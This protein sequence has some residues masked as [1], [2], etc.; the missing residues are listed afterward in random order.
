MAASQ[1]KIATK[2]RERGKREQLPEGRVRPWCLHRAAWVCLLQ[3]SGPLT[4]RGGAGPNLNTRRA[5]RLGLARRFVVGVH[6]IDSWQS[7]KFRPL[8][9]KHPS[10]KS[11]SLVTLRTIDE[12]NRTRP[13][14][15]RQFI[16]QA[17]RLSSR[18]AFV[19]Q[20]RR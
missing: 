6:V 18:A 15:S 19:R 7:K 3:V 4:R 13:P 1:R 17:T 10:H 8:F 20:G 5:L 14:Q 16:A 11:I 12:R 9:K 2:G